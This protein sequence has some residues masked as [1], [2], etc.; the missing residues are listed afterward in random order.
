MVRIVLP[1]CVVGLLIFLLKNFSGCGFGGPGS[2]PGHGPGGETESGNVLISVEGDN[3]LLKGKVTSLEDV[4]SLA[5][6]QGK[7]QKEVIVS[8]KRNA[9]MVAIKRLEDELSK[10]GVRYRSENEFQ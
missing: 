8:K 5:Y 10:R 2:G 9:R 7:I 6:D 4:V 3:Y 1:I